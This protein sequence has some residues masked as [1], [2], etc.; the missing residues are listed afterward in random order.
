M[1]RKEFLRR[2]AA[3]GLGAPLFGMLLESCEGQAALYP[4]FDVNFSGNVLVVGAGAAG[5]TAG[6]LLD[7]YD[8]DFQILEASSDFGGRMKRSSNFADFPIDLGAEWIHTDPSILA[9]LISNQGID[10]SIDIITYS[11]ETIYTW[12]NE[13]LRSQNWAS[14]FYSEYK[15]KNTTW[16][17]FFE[18]YFMSNIGNRIVYN[19]PVTTIDYSGNRVVVQNADGETFD[20]DKVLVTVP[21]KILQENSITF[22][23]S[24]PDAKTGAINSITMPDGIKVFID[25]SERFYPDL[26]FTG[27]LI[28]QSSES[29]KLYY[30]AAFRKDSNSNV[31]GLFTVGSN[32]TPY[33]SAASDQE[34]IEI[35][36]NELDTIFDGKAS[37]YY[38]NHIIQ[39]WS[40]EPFIQG[41]YSTE[42]DG[43]HSRIVS[44]LAASISNKL[45]FA[46][47]ATSIENGSTV[48]GAGESAYSAVEEMIS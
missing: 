14:N 1:T 2:S 4:E 9:R 38:N 3:F 7:R 18:N 19:S 33:A 6:Y 29:E 43:S 32:A 30:D 25:F 36:M 22:T 17:G 35:V 28:S 37:R 47:E 8:V 45:Y 16:F 10:A 27:G 31:L 34:T 11:P 44:D 26:L 48:H 24:L 12:K 46:G 23:P 21:I 13:T 15:F 42:F 5:I 20:A 39:N 40:K 41:S